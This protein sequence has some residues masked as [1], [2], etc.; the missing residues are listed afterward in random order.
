VGVN[1][2]ET[3]LTI[4]IGT[5]ASGNITS[6]DITENFFASYPEFS[7]ENPTDFYC[8]FQAS[9]SDSGDQTSLAQDLDT[10]YCPAGT[11]VQQT[12]TWSSVDPPPPAPEPQSYLLFGSGLVV[13]LALSRLRQPAVTK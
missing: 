3:P 6:W 7:G 8:V 13:L 1:Y 9:T 12:G 4:E 2:Y 5:D 11:G 10:G